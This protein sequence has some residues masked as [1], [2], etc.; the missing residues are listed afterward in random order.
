LS[1]A[2]PE[3][4]LLCH[5]IPPLPESENAAIREKIDS[6]GPR[7]VVYISSTGVYGEATEAGAETQPAP[8]DERGRQRI[9]EER[10]IASGNWS[11]L[12]LRAAAIYGSGRGV[13]RAVLEGRSPRGSTAQVV[14]RIH[15]DDLAAM[16]EAGLFSEISGAWPVADEL[17]CPSAEIAD[18]T[19]RLAGLPEMRAKGKEFLVSGRKVD[20]SAIRKLLGVR[21]AYPT[22]HSG[23]LATLAEE[24]SSSGPNV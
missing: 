24:R 16:A 14:S 22:W 18:W 2:A 1:A 6:L 17:P 3:G 21:L 10:W 8:N 20:G 4:G 19:A 7:R 13:H 5:A 23:V 12:I 9:R 15:V 11:S